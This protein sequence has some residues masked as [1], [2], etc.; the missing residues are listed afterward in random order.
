MAS[1]GRITFGPLA[2]CLLVGLAFVAPCLAIACCTGE[3]GCATP[4][5]CLLGL[6]LTK[7]MFLSFLHKSQA[8][9]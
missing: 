8:F 1:L 7:A 4:G 3:H 6:L 9:T 2:L 5:I